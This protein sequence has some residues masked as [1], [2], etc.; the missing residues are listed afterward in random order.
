VYSCPNARCNEIFIGYFKRDTQLNVYFPFGA[1]PIEPV[2][3]AFEEPIKQIS[4]A[5][6]SIYEE[7]H[8]AEQ[9]GLTEVC[10]VGYRK[11]LEFLIKATS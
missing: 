8:K 2:P 6:C 5:F 1:R 11:A 4:S 3:L 7:A 10:G 9:F